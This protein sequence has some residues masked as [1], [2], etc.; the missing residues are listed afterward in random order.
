VNTRTSL[1]VPAELAADALRRS[2]LP[3]D[4]TLTQLCRFALARLAGW[5]PAAALAVSKAKGKGGL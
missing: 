5:P 3:R 1:T 2:G 4:A